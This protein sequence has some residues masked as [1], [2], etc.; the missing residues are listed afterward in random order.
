[1]HS[2][3]WYNRGN[4][5]KVVHN[6]TVCL[7]GLRIRIWL[8][9]GLGLIWNIILML[10]LICL[11]DVGPTLTQ[12][13]IKVQ[14][15]FNQVADLAFK[16]L[17]ACTPQD[18]AA[19]FHILVQQSGESFM[20]FSRVTEAVVRQ[21]DAEPVRD[22]LIQELAQEGL[23]ALNFNAVAALRNDVIHPCPVAPLHL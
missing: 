3:S 23:N 11:L 7:G 17:K 13:S 10:L 5:L 19:Y 6:T 14:D 12:A 20:D 2:Q 21:V 8:R 1:M 4:L 9:I 16:D 15:D 22:M 18:P